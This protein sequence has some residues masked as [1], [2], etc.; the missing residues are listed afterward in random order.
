MP[1]DKTICPHCGQKMK[2]FAPP[3]ESTWGASHWYV[4]FNND[5]GYYV[6]GWDHMWNT[7]AVKCSYRHRYDPESDSC[8]PMPVYSANMGLN[9]VVEE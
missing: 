3:S 1:E 8:G 7:R 6:R 2:K 4:C 9:C 5:C